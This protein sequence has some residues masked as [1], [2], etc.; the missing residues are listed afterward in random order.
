MVVLEDFTIDNNI[1]FSYVSP[2][3]S[4]FGTEDALPV[5]IRN[6]FQVGVECPARCSSLISIQKLSYGLCS[7]PADRKTHKSLSLWHR[8]SST[9]ALG[10]IL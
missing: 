5:F 7:E 8:L 1:K 10:E 4:I 6:D 3:K 2:S 9:D